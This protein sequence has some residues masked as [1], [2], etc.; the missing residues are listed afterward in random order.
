M[1]FQRPFLSQCLDV[2]VL[3]LHGDLLVIAEVGGDVDL[4]KGA[5]AKLPAQ[6][7]PPGYPDIHVA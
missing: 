5:A 3:K 4:T 1:S 2:P 7:E 6:L